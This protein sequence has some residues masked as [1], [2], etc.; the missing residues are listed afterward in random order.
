MLALLIAEL[1]SSSLVLTDFSYDYDVI[2]P[3]S[4]NFEQEN[5]EDIEWINLRRT[6]IIL[7]LFFVFSKGIFGWLLNLFFFGHILLNFFKK[8]FFFYDLVDLLMML[9]LQETYIEIC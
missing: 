8:V 2:F 7:S 4:C 5:L 9:E 3:F 6:L 1:I